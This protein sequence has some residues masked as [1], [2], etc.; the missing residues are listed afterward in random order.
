MEN[1]HYVSFVLQQ[2]QHAPNEWVKCDD[3]SLSKASVSE[4]L[5]NEA[6]L[7]FYCKRFFEYK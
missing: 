7:L 2:M 1:G 6:Y 5:E 4:V 3:E